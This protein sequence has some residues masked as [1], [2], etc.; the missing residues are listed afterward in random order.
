MDLEDH[1]YFKAHSLVETI[2]D[3][4]TRGLAAQVQGKLDTFFCPG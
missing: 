2:G 3:G 1:P 4:A